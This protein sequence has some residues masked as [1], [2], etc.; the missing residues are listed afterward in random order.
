MHLNWNVLL[1]MALFCIFFYCK[2][3]QTQWKILLKS[4]FLSEFYDKLT[5]T[6]IKLNKRYHLLSIT[7]DIWIIFYYVLFCFQCN[8]INQNLGSRSIFS[9]P[10][11]RKNI[12]I[13]KSI[14]RD[15]FCGSIHCVC[16]H[17]NQ[18]GAINPGTISFWGLGVVSSNISMS[19]YK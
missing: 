17:G 13:L 6:Y 10:L 2:C 12:P 18:L 16:H 11:L 3:Y 14:Y 8:R 4:E 7:H 9:N 15:Y 1:S 5:E 19:E